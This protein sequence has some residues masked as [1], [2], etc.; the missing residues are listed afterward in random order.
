VKGER[1]GRHSLIGEEEGQQE[2]RR[3]RA[4]RVALPL[5]LEKLDVPVCEN[6]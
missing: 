2:G 5:K 6:H 4:V 1:T 3:E